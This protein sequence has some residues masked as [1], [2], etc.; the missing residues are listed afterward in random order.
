[1]MRSRKVDASSKRDTGWLVRQVGTGLPQQPHA[2]L[3]TSRHG[4]T[5]TSIVERDGELLAF[6]DWKGERQS[7]LPLPQNNTGRLWRP[8]GYAEL[9]L[10]AQM[11]AGRT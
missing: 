6:D 2:G 8:A 9:A 5:T 3:K 7:R 11:I 1:M 10:R 4:W